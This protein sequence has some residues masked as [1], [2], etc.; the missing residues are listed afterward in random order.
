MIGT[1]L[2]EISLRSTENP[3]VA[4]KIGR[5][6]TIAMSLT[7]EDTANRIF[8]SRGSVMPQRNPPTR[9][10]MPTIWAKSPQAIIP[11]NKYAIALP[12]MDPSGLIPRRMTLAI[13]GRTTIIDPATRI[14][15][16]RSLNRSWP[17][18]D[19]AATVPAIPM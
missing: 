1:T 10:L 13:N 3:A 2:A 12:E 4:K 6:R 14:A 11:A 19:D 15:A 8:R 17:A 18:P 5:N 9:K 16:N 7:R